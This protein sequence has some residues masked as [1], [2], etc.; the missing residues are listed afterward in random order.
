MKR[1]C[2]I[3]DCLF[4]FGHPLLLQGV[5]GPGGNQHLDPKGVVTSEIFVQPPSESAIAQMNHPH[6]LHYLHER[7]RP[8]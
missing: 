4:S 6:V 7:R 1:V 3:D 8:C 5:L 2:L